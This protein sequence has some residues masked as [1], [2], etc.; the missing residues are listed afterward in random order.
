M[1]AISLSSIFTLPRIRVACAVLNYAAIVVA[2]KL[3]LERAKLNLTE[4]KGPLQRDARLGDIALI[5][6][7]SVMLLLSSLGRSGKIAAAGYGALSL[8][9]IGLLAYPHYFDDGSREQMYLHGAG[10]VGVHALNICGIATSGYTLLTHGYRVNGLLGLGGG[11]VAMG[12]CT[13]LYP[14]QNK[15]A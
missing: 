7:A 3:A 12:C 5:S 14:L 13:W 1:Q 15:Y 2:A 11:A 8:V 9:G 4:E 10:L 6:S